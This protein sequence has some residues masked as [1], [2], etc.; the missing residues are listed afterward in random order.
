[1]A[2]TTSSKATAEGSDPLGCPQQLGR[3]DQRTH[4]HALRLN[5]PRAMQPRAVPNVHQAAQ[6]SPTLARLAA[7]AQDSQTCLNILNHLLPSALR[8]GVQAGPLENGEWCLLAANSA[9]AAK[10]R[11]LSPALM[12]HLRSQGWQVTAIRIKVQGR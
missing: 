2:Y 4:L 8:T 1:M 9:V 6:Q 10:L 3:A 11:Q 7:A 12:A 5:Y